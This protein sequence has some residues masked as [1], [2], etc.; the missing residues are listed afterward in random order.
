MKIWTTALAL[1]PVFILALLA[2]C[3]PVGP[4]T[5]AEPERFEYEE[6]LW[7]CIV[8]RLGMAATDRPKELF[9]SE[10]FFTQTQTL[11]TYELAH[12]TGQSR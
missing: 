3:S 2:A 4:N 11:C 7:D 6:K 5:W 1:A 10:G 8:E 12:E 9:A